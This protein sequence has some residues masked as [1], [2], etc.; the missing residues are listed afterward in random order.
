MF[1]HIK[2]FFKSEKNVLI[3]GVILVYG[4]HFLIRVLSHQNFG[5]SD[6]NDALLTNSLRWA[7]QADA[8][9]L[10]SW[11]L[12]VAMSVVGYSVTS[13]LLVKYAC[14]AL[15]CWVIFKFYLIFSANKK[16][17]LLT[18]FSVGSCYFMMWRLHEV[19]TYRLLTTLM[20]VTLSYAYFAMRSMRV[21]VRIGVLAGLFGLGFLTE[22]YVVVALAAM[23]VLSLDRRTGWAVHEVLLSALLGLALAFPFFEWLYQG[24]LFTQYI[25]WG[26]RVDIWDEL[27]RAISY[28]IYVLSPAVF[29]FLPFLFRRGDSFR[30]FLGKVITP[31]H[32]NE[33]HLGKYLLTCYVLWVVL[34]GLFLPSAMVGPQSA[35]PIFLPV[36]I[37]L[38]QRLEAAKIKMLWIAVV[39]SL[40]PATAAYFRVGNLLVLDKF[41]TNC[42]W[43]IPYDKLAKS[44]EG[45]MAGRQNTTIQS[46]SADILA[47]LKQFI[48]AANFVLLGGVITPLT[49]SEAVN[50]IIIEEALPKTDDASKQSSTARTTHLQTKW[51]PPYL[52]THA[53]DRFSYWDVTLGAS[54][55]QA[56]VRP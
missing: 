18:A 49:D 33:N 14:A 2:K 5:D 46:H 10:Y 13:F 44:I 11:L 21:W 36:L 38:F 1:C 50:S 4:F 42:R 55:N 43:A 47:N 6:A 39:L 32:S 24:A 48:P 3:G 45:C 41:C 9:P 25:G 15:I 27:R 35:L 53:Y 19:M 56:C 34:F 26:G 20:F 8:G 16:F 28:P 23:L 12:Y 29:L 52:S 30:S 54:I 51:H 40:L 7:Y 22:I 37:L 31:A 17:A